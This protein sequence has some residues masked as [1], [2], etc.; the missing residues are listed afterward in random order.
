MAAALTAR[1]HLDCYRKDTLAEGT[2]MR[3]ESR[4]GPPGAIF[5]RRA[6]LGIAGCGAKNP[7]KHVIA[8]CARTASERTVSIGSNSSVSP[9]DPED[10][11]E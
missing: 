2:L 7:A 9:S 6:A 5:P 3:K 10:F 11:G 1:D 8:A 4:E